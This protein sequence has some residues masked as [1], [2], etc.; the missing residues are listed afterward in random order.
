MKNFLK[1]GGFTMKSMNSSKNNTINKGKTLRRLARL[2]KPY[3]GK[4]I[5][6]TL[7]VIYVNLAQLVKPFILKK[8]I[9]DFLVKKTPSQ[10]LYSINTM[11]IL[12]FLIIVSSG[13][14]SVVQ[15]NT[16]TIVGQK[17]MK[18]IRTKI[19][20][21]IQYLPLSYLDKISSGRLVTRCTN[22]VEAL[23]E[24]YTDIIVNLFKDIILIIGI[25]VSM[26]CMDVRLAGISLCMI[27]L[28]AGLVG[29]IKNKAKKNFVDMKSVIGRINGFMAEN[30]SG[31]KLVQLFCGEKIKNKEFKDLNDEYYKTTKFQIQLNSFLRPASDVF[32]N[33][34]IAIIIWYSMS[35]INAG[36]VEIGV[37]YAFTTYIKQFFNPISN[38]AESYTSIQS[39]LVSGDRIFEIIDLEDELEDVQSGKDMLN[40]KGDVEFKNV[41]FAYRGE[42]WILKDVS[43]KINRGETGAF[44]GETGAGKTTI[45]SLISGFYIPQKGDILIDGVSIRDIKLKT[46]RQRICV[47][48]QDVFLFSGNIEKN[49]TLNDDIP[50]DNVN[51]ALSMSCADEFVDNMPEG[52]E[53]PVMESGSTFSAGQKQLIS[54]ARA[55]AHSPAILVLDEATANIDTETEVLIQKAIENSSRDRT[56]LVIA[57]RLSTIRNADKI[58]VLKHGE[59]LET[60]NHDELMAKNGYYK[61]LI[62]NSAKSE[63]S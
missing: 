13:A 45:I 49:I 24:L 38:L 15:A 51:Q 31:M 50:E 52:L 12:Y 59:V 32:Q 9:D 19:F 44:V 18:G 36:V 61:N 60:G 4:I 63:I 14:I 3:T 35:R 41:W 29:I 46:L 28:I 47:V 33:I 22:D 57:H 10:G 21:V 30:I 6:A 54:F 5:V 34:T 42:E 25:V 55:L 53:E 56:T 7:C 8:V 20:R 2:T 16:I 26:V 58:I 37:L 23:S 40:M 39:A 11:A 48:L 1:K 62:E 17:I 43:F 27:P